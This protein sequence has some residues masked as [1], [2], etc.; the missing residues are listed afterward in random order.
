VEFGFYLT[1]YYPD[2]QALPF[3]QLYDEVIEQGRIAEDLGYTSLSI[4]EH[5]FGNYLMIPSPLLLATKVAEHTRHV[6]IV[7]AVLVLPFYDIRRLAGEITLAD[8]LTGGRVEFGLGRGAFRYEFD[9]MG[10]RPE[11][12]QHV[13]RESVLLLQKLL[14]ETDV[15]W[16]GEYYTIEE[17]LTVMPRPLQ[18]PHP[19]F[20]IAS[21]SEQSIRWAVEHG[22]HLQTT[23]L[24]NPW[25]VTAQQALDFVK[26]RDTIGAGKGL[27]HHMLRNVYVSKDKRDLEEKKHLLFENHRRFTNL[28]ETPGTIEH[29]YAV[30]IDVPMTPDEAVANVIFGYPDDVIERLHAH[31]ELEIDA[32][33]V[34]MAFGADHADIVKCMELFAEEVMPVFRRQAETVTQ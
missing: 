23:P 5:H 32:I 9:R 6:P 22:F 18:S 7:S 16:S 31:A 17:P 30:P 19:P 21:L 33:Q 25:E 4:P 3:K 26:F 34:N 24:R 29:G 12:S 8:H 15:T 10:V 14:T 20:W 28:F 1:C 13:F 27:Q 2:G 11:K